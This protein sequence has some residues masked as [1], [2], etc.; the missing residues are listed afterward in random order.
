M[1]NSLQTQGDKPIDLTEEISP[2]EA[3]YTPNRGVIK[4]SKLKIRFLAEFEKNGY[5]IDGLE[6]PQYLI[7]K[8]RNEPEFWAIVEELQMIGAKARAL[9]MSL[10]D[11]VCLDVINGKDVTDQQLIGLRLG[12]QR[13]LKQ[14]PTVA[15]QVNNNQQPQKIDF[16]FDKNDAKADG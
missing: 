10:V 13:L 6:T 5:V 2:I 15:V 8:W 14:S 7:D 4:I 3:I 16:Q 9:N 11:S 12:Y 1:D